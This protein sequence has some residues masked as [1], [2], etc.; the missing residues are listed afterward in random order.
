M[1]VYANEAIREESERVR[2]PGERRPGCGAERR[3]H[4]WLRQGQA[5]GGGQGLQSGQ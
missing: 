4:L 3:D 2:E 5:E 1:Q